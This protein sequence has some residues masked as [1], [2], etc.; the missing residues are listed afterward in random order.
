M[1]ELKVITEAEVAELEEVVVPGD[2][3]IIKGS[4]C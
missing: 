1:E 2:F 3:C 4:G